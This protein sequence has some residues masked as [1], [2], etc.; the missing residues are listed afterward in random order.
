MLFVTV[1]L[2][3]VMTSLTVFAAH[4]DG[5]TKVTARIE[6]TSTA[7]TQLVTDGDSNSDLQD[8]SNISTGEILSVLVIISFILLVISVLVIFVLKKQ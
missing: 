8:E 1:C 6:V 7:T 2:I 3:L 5:S 4:T